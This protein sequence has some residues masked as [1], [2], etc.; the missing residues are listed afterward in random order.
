MAHT[1][2]PHAVEFFTK[3]FTNW[4]ICFITPPRR[5]YLGTCQLDAG[6]FA[7]GV[8]NVGAAIKADPANFEEEAHQRLRAGRQVCRTLHPKR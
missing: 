8:A 1:G 3:V 7:E 6:R 4:E 5:Y 2:I